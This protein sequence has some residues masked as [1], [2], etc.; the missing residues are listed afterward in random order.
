MCILSC[1]LNYMTLML[2]LILRLSQNIFK[3]YGLNINQYFKPSWTLQGP[4][5]QQCVLKAVFELPM[6]NFSSI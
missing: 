2:V 3:I 5:S 6:V 1:H 4:A